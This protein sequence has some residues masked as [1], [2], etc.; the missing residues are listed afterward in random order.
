DEILIF[1]VN[2]SFLE[3]SDLTSVGGSSGI[4]LYDISGGDVGSGNEIAIAFLQQNAG[5][6]EDLIIGTDIFIV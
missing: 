3:I 6:T 4:I 1:G 2:P 5:L